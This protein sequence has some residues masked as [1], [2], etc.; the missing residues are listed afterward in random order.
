MDF[1]GRVKSCTRK[2][3]EGQRTVNSTV[4]EKAVCGDGV[5]SSRP[6]TLVLSLDSLVNYMTVAEKLTFLDLP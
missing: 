6:Y 4:K 3:E 2:E 1:L 5:L